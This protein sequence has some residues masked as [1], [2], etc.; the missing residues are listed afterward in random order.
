VGGFEMGFEAIVS[1]VQDSTLDAVNQVSSVALYG[2]AATSVA[3]SHLSLPDWAAV[4]SMTV[5]VLGFCIQLALAIRMFVRDR[6]EARIERDAA[7]IE[8]EEQRKER[9]VTRS[10]R[11]SP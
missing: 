3:S 11:D 7:R 9:V 1:K 8:R 2:G 10:E 5:A 4:I 6:H